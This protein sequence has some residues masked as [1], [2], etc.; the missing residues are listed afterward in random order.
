MAAVDLN[1]LVSSAVEAYLREEQQSTDGRAPEK[2]GHRRLGRGAA[3]AT[4]AGLAVAG[5][6]AYRRIRHLDLE[7]LGRAAQKKLTS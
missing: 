2:K 6:A 5:R 4:G 7:Q 1:K 3:V